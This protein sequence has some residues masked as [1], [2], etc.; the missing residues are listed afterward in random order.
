M[1]IESPGRRPRLRP[2]G[3]RRIRPCRPRRCAGV[4]ARRLE[5]SGETSTPTP[6]APGNLVEQRHQQAPEPMPRSST[7]TPSPPCR[8]SS[9]AMQRGGDDRL[10]VGPRHQGGGRERE[11]KAPEL[12]FAE[13]ARHRLAGQPPADMA[14]ELGGDAGRPASRAA[15]G[16]GRD[17]AARRHRASAGAHRAAPS[18]SRG[19]EDLAQPLERTEPGRLRRDSVGVPSL[20]VAAGEIRSAHARRS[21]SQVPSAHGRIPAPLTRILLRGEQ[22]RLVLGRRARRSARRARSRP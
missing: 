12:P 4:E 6:V 21:L 13:D 14:G 17:A 8:R 22:R 3:Q 18:R 11:G 10:A 7:R 20:S 9:S 5:A 1:Q 19:A 15:R 2:V 16:S